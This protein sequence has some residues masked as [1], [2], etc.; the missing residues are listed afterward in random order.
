MSLIALT[1]SG[2]VRNLRCSP[3]GLLLAAFAP[4]I[5]RLYDIGALAAN[6][7]TYSAAL[8]LGVAESR[9]HTLLLCI[10]RGVASAGEVFSVESSLDG[11]DWVT[12]NNAAGATASGSNNT[13]S[14]TMHNQARPFGRYVRLRYQNGST[15]Q[16]AL[17]LHLTAIAG[18]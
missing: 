8:D 18:V 16:T 17:K 1:N 3:E 9:Q 14:P 4:P 11:V 13:S 15:A 2:D 10:K 7:T 5:E 12:T 6:A